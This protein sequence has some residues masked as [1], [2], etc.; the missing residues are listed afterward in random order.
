MALEGR[1]NAANCIGDTTAS[2][3]PLASRLSLLLD[4]HDKVKDRRAFWPGP[5]P[6]WAQKGA[7]RV[8]HALG[9]LFIVIIGALNGASPSTASAHAQ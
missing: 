3:R 1:E 2:C 9:Y 6:A 5:I 7:T 4:L 8:R